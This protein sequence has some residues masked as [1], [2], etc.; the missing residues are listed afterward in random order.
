MKNYLILILLFIIGLYIF[1]SNLVKTQAS[2]NKYYYTQKKNSLQAAEKLA[3]L[4]EFLNKL[5]VHLKNDHKTHKNIQNKLKKNIRLSEINNTKYIAYTL[6]KSSLHIC[7]RNKF[8]GFEKNLNSAYFVIMHEL[9]HII[10]TSYGHT[11]E[12]WENYE[13]VIKTAIDHNLY[14]YQNYHKDPVEYCNKEITSTPYMKGGSNDISISNIAIG[15]LLLVLLIYLYNTIKITIKINKI[16]GINEDSYIQ[17]IDKDN[18]VFHQG[19]ITD[20]WGDTISLPKK[21][22]HLDKL[23]LKDVK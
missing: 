11:E 9:A 20:I 3:E 17:N 8:G 14:T 10:T 18:I 13:L 16:N 2:N 15:L 1:N 22:I 5:I 23:T 4:D 7:L 12:Y 21:I 19:Y 6:N